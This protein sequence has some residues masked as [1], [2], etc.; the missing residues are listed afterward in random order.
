MMEINFLL[1]WELTNFALLGNFIAT[2]NTT[3]HQIVRAIA[4]LSIFV[5]RSVNSLNGDRANPLYLSRVC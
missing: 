4:L 1:R 5:S 3:A 2:R